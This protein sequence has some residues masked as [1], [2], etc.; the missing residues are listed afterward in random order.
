MSKR[1]YKKSKNYDAAKAHIESAK[2][3][4]QELGG[5]D[6]DV[7]KWFFNLSEDNL[8]RIFE[9]YKS[10]HGSEAYKYAIKTYPKWQAG[11]TNMSGLVAERLFSILPKY[12]TIKE[13]Y[14]LV[15]SLWDHVSPKE[16][17]IILIGNITPINES[18]KI[19]KNEIMNLSTNW[20]IPEGLKKR[21]IWLDSDDSNIYESFLSHIKENEKRQA[22]FIIE[23][24]IPVLEKKFKEDW[25]DVSQ[26]LKYEI[27]I[28]KQ[29]ITV[30]IGNTESETVCMSLDAYNTQIR[31]RRMAIQM[32]IQKSNQ[33]KFIIGFIVFLCF[34]IFINN[35]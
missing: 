6:S 33:E 19:I 21:F 30:I 28:G 12:M 29:K 2:R 1:K 4:S 13:K 9:D 23:N 14:K 16:Q 25:M 8:K 11:K 20:K 26:N 15:D 18:I 31:K 27:I 7:K 22:S 24:Q 10:K 35:F 5:T 34:L 3:L 32:A 17:S